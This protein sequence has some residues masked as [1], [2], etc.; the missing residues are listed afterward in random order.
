[1][2]L[3]WA[4][5][6]SGR[7]SKRSTSRRPGRTFSTRRRCLRWAALSGHDDYHFYP[8]AHAF[9]DFSPDLQSQTIAQNRTLTNAGIRGD[10]SHA[11]GIH[12]LKAGVLYQHTLL[13][14]QTTGLAPSILV[15]WHCSISSTP[16]LA[17]RFQARHA[18]IQAVIR[19]RR[20]ARCLPPAISH[21]SSFLAVERQTDRR[22]PRFAEVVRLVQRTGSWGLR[23]T[24]TR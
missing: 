17:L 2:V 3:F 10:I 18:W 22:Y 6:I 19:L 16:C 1:M 20:H 9:A 23:F 14:P 11:K 12:N 21:R 15:S 4:T 24:G 13:S 8:S 5:P 7:R